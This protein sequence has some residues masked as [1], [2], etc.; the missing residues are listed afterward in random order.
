MNDRMMS[1]GI[2][3][4]IEN[5]V[6]NLE[7]AD[8]PE[9]GCL[10]V[11]QFSGKLRYIKNN[12]EKYLNTGECLVADLAKGYRFFYDGESDIRTAY[13]VSCGS[14]V[15]DILELYRVQDGCVVP[16]PDMSGTLFK[17][18]KVSGGKVSDIK[19]KSELSALYFHT[20]IVAIDRA[21]KEFEMTAKSTASLIKDYIDSHVESRLQLEDISAVFFISKTQIFRL[22]KEAYEIAPMQ[23]FLQKKIEL[24]K[25]MLAETDMLVADIAER[26]AFT[27]AKHFSKTFKKITGE[28]P[29]NYRHTVKADASKRPRLL[30]E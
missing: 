21:R 3:T 4:L 9:E 29:K 10:I 7:T 14:I 15:K 1:N 11:W 25:Q 13:S 17:I 28:L 22:F 12:V 6:G 30:S 5:S 2:F 23:Y 24:A 16:I 18:Q 26:L 19:D 20:V 8:L 27:D